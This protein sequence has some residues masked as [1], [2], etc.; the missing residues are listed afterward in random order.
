MIRATLQAPANDRVAPKTHELG[1]F[2]SVIVGSH[3][4]ATK[5]P[6]AMRLLADVRVHKQ[7]TVFVM[8]G[9][10]PGEEWLYYEVLL[11]DV[12]APPS[13]SAGSDPGDDPDNVGY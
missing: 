1:V 6:R 2:N 13:E 4:I 12:P 11:E 5:G 7:C 8:D 10:K 3:G 9:P